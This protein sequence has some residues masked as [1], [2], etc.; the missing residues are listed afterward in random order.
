MSG[1]GGSAWGG[2]GAFGSNDVVVASGNPI[3]DNV[4][5]A[6][7]TV[8]G[9]LQTLA[10]DVDGVGTLAPVVSVRFDNGPEE[11]VHDGEAFRGYFDNPRSA[12]SSIADGYHFEI[13]RAGGWTGPLSVHVRATV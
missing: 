6:E 3:V 11:V 8:L 13:Y 1:F 5:P 7:G 10:F 2:G 12:R 9:V 4:V